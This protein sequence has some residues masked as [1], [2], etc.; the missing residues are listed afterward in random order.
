MKPKNK[1]NQPIVIK[2]LTKE[3]ELTIDK[4]IGAL[5]HSRFAV[6]RTTL[7]EKLGHRGI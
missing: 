2:N 3:R 6:L 4:S 5:E 1:S 7:I